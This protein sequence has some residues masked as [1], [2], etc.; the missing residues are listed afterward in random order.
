MEYKHDSNNDGVMKS[1][2]NIA[3]IVFLLIGA[4]FLVTEHWAHLSGWIPYWPYL[5]LLA[6]P[7]M[8]RFMHGGHG[9]GGHEPREAS[10]ESTQEKK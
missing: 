9:H 3:L 6:C 4:Y 1:R 2:A 5:L 8:H 10:T 7:L